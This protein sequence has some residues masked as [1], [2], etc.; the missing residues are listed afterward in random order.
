MSIWRDFIK[1]CKEKDP[2]KV[3]M[4]LTDLG[5]ALIRAQPSVAPVIRL[6]NDLLCQVE[7]MAVSDVWF[8]SI[9]RK[10]VEYEAFSKTALNKLIR[11]AKRL[12]NFSG[13]VLTYSYS[14]VV[15]QSILAAK[16]AGMKFGVMTS[17]AR[18]ANEG[19]MTAGMLAKTGI[20]VQYMTDVGLLSSIATASV[21]LLGADAIL[22]EAV[23]NKI[24]SRLI[25]EKAR[26]CGVP[27]YVLTMTN[28]F[29]PRSLLPFFEIQDKNPQEIWSKAPKSVTP[30]NRYFDQ[31]PMEMI[32]G[33]I[34][35]EGMVR[36]ETLPGFLHQINLSEKLKQRLRN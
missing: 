13:L 21:V 33:M 28:K 4:G 25:I 14:S 32:T 35:E 10:A 11:F 8:T 6:A 22:P 17:E 18:P 20:N 12:L 24:G 30:Q 34:T 26:S 9:L 36:P 23:V 16:R 19:Q 2:Y 1:T 3:T 7:T 31:T 29:L 15:T 27:V 5:M